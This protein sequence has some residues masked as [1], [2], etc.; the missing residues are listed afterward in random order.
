MLRKIDYQAK[1]F[2]L[3]EV[4]VS[5]IILSLV[6]IGIIN[7]FVSGKRWILH[8]R[9]RMAGGELGKLFLAPL[10]TGVRADTWGDVGNP[11][12]LGL[13][14]C[15]GVG[16]HTQQPG[17]PS[18]QNRTLDNIAYSAQYDINNVTTRAE[19]NNIRRVVATISWNA[20]TQ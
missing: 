14:Y 15:D 10:Q 8:S 7:V 3:L 16:G 9:E 12:A 1:G 6:L 2:T 13:S 4:L 5:I 18:S 17:C 19:P 11:L 20:P